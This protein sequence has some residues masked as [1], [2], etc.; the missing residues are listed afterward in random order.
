M[1]S[2]IVPPPLRGRVR[3][4]GIDTTQA[5]FWTP[6]WQ[7][8]EREASKDIRSGRVRRYKAA[9]DFLRSLGE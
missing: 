1:V 6:S 2:E 7:K 9:K 4:G 8:R 3:V 5:W